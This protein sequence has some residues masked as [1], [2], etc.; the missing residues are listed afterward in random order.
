MNIV[1]VGG[2]TVGR[3]GNDVVQSARQAGHTVRVLSHRTSKDTNAT[4]TFLSLDNAVASFTNVT[5]DLEHI[6]ILLYNTTHKGHP[7]D[8][9]LF[10]SK[11]VINE[12]LYVHGFYVQVLIP[13]ALAIEALKKMDNTSKII[14]MTT[15]VI[16]DREHT[17]NL[18]HLGYY[19][20]KAYQHQLM[21]A[22]AD[23]NDK[24]VVVS[25]ISPYFDYE[26]KQKYASAF[27]VA[28]NHILNDTHNGKVFDC[29]EDYAR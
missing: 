5:L 16:Y 17:E 7:N 25:A 22:L 11:G 18:H 27:N 6:D 4:L 10:T 1:I 14:F 23:C 13:H 12:K 9:A 15:D 21:L 2:G 3:F 29:W 20:G 26:D 28:Y 24:G 8:A 19:G